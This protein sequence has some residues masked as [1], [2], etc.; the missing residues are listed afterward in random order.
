MCRFWRNSPLPRWT[1]KSKSSSPCFAH[2]GHKRLPSPPAESPRHEHH[3]I[4]THHRVDLAKWKRSQPWQCSRLSFWHLIFGFAGQRSWTSALLWVS[5]TQCRLMCHPLIILQTF[6]FTQYAL[7]LSTWTLICHTEW[8]FIGHSDLFRTSPPMEIIAFDNAPRRHISLSR[9]AS[10]QINGASATQIH[11]NY[12]RRFVVGLISAS[13][14]NRSLFQFVLV[15]CSDLIVPCW[16]RRVAP[17]VWLTCEPGERRGW[18]AEAWRTPRKVFFAKDNR[19]STMLRSQSLSLVTSLWLQKLEKWLLFNHRNT[20][21][22]LT[23]RI[24]KS[25]CVISQEPLFLCER[26]SVQETKKGVFGCHETEKV[27]RQETLF[28]PITRELQFFRQCAS[29]T[30]W[31]CVTALCV[32]VPERDSADQTSFELLYHVCGGEACSEMRSRDPRLETYWWSHLR[33]RR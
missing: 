27:A 30:Q 18:A 5:G 26:T 19:G 10:A 28:H 8:I 24:S 7:F 32:T 16:T 4:W 33:G 21:L 3:C 15:L 2:K 29:R 1:Q 17:S 31:L 13:E 12:R 25:H 22:F 20:T 11:H 9:K 14:T 23:K 6:M